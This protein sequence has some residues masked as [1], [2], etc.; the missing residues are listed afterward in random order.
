[1]T[2]GEGVILSEQQAGGLVGER[3][4]RESTSRG[5]KRTSWVVCTGLSC[6]FSFDPSPF[7]ALIF[8]KKNKKKKKQRKR[9]REGKREGE[10]ERKQKKTQ[11]RREKKKHSHVPCWEGKAHE[12]G[13]EG[14]SQ[15]E[16]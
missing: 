3:E 13:L 2:G 16:A 7:L 8:W 12:A 15:S 10:Q 9:E 6:A 1:M 4:G 11:G 5:H 14:K